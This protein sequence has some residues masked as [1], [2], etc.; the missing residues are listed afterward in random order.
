VFALDGTPLTK[1]IFQVLDE[2][3]GGV[4]D[5]N[6]LMITLDKYR[7]MRYVDR[8]RWCYKV[9]DSDSNGVVDKEELGNLIADMD[10]SNRTAKSVNGTTK[11]LEKAFERSQHTK[12]VHINEDQFVELA[13]QHPNLLVYPAFGALERILCVAFHDPDDHLDCYARCLG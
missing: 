9:Y 4:L 6:D 5:A 13:K 1:T 7:R 3:G 11:K 8:I 2:N 10:F 12:M